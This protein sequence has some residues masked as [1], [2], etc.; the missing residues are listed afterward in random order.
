MPLPK[1]IN[2]LTTSIEEAID[3]YASGL[4][5]IQKSIYSKMLTQLKD[6]STDAEGNITS[7][8]EN[9]K[10]IARVKNTIKK[11]L[12]SDTYIKQVSKID[13]HYSEIRNIQSSYFTDMFADFEVPK[14]LAEF[15][16]QAITSTVD[17]LTESGVQPEIMKKAGMIL[18]DNL[19]SGRNLTDMTKE[20]E[21][22]IL[23]N[24][25]VPGKLVSYSKQIINDGLSQFAGHYTALV[26]DDL[27]LQWFG[28]VGGL[29]RE[30][31]PMCRCLV[32][33]K[34]IHKSEITSICNGL[35]DGEQISKAGMIE[36][37]DESNFMVNRG[38]WQCQHLLVPLSPE[39]V[40]KDLRSE[41]E[42]ETDIENE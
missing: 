31:R 11:E 21:E 7:T 39:F 9:Y 34:Y 22:Y 27:D 6:L 40:P 4:T 24:D 13:D 42:T 17:M 38:G 28:Y 16:K 26:T 29:V 18:N 32:A 37:T 41:F 2:D 10:I 12:N 20:L 23:G 14:V 25:N 36:G 1:S 5:S 8:I 33:K 3:G 15:Q 35:V 19:R 30:S